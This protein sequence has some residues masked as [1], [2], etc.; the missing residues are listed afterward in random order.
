[1]CI[2]RG[3]FPKTTRAGCEG[4]YSSAPIPLRRGEERRAGCKGL[5]QLG[6]TPLGEKQ[7]LSSSGQPL[8][9]NSFIRI[10]LA[11]VL[12][13]CEGKA[14][15]AAGGRGTRSQEA[16]DRHWLRKRQAGC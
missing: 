11:E 4:L 3:H 15:W 8:P 7:S 6:T 16:S 12:P 9:S 14:A 1:M 5:Q 2:C 13:V 10:Q